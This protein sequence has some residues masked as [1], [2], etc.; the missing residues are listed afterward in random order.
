MQT[1]D[2]SKSNI[3]IGGVPIDTAA[4]EGISFDSPGQD[5][6]ELVDVSG[7]VTRSRL[8]QGFLVATLTLLLG[9]QGHAHLQ[10]LRE[11]D[12]KTGRGAFALY[13]RDWASGSEYASAKAYIRQQP[14]QAFGQEAT[15]VVYTIVMPAPRVTVNQIPD[16]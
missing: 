13:F 2:L 6:G 12:L 5:W 16:L 10:R 15:T 4:T 9:G 7:G 3:V 11:V 8:A 14:T 1:Y